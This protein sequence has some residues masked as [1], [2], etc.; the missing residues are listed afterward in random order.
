MMRSLAKKLSTSKVVK[1]CHRVDHRALVDAQVSIEGSHSDEDGERC[2]YCGRG[3]G[4]VQ[5]WLAASIE[6][7]EGGDDV[8]DGGRNRERHIGN[9][10][11]LAV[12]GFWRCNLL[13]G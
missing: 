4:E 3:G 11:P 5:W 6:E 13:D 7:C 12:R 8:N 1:R 2:V 10:F 9:T